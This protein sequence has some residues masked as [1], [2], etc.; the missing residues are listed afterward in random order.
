MRG[1][2]WD[3]IPAYGLSFA[4]SRSLPAALSS[5]AR[6]ILSSTDGETNIEIARRLK[7]S[8]A[9]VGK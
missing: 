9:T 7:L 4:R 5:R 2:C 8:K 6:I 3:C 1:C